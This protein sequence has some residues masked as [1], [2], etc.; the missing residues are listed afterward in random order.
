MGG[1]PIAPYGDID[2]NYANIMNSN[3]AAYSDFLRFKK[4]AAILTDGRVTK[5]VK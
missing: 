3:L 4:N 2:G 5:R 1:N